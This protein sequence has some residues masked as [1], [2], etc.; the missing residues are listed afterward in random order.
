MLHAAYVHAAYLYI[1]ML[2]HALRRRSQCWRTELRLPG[3]D[4]SHAFARCVML[5]NV[6]HRLA[7]R[8]L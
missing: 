7:S 6:A 1:C 2:C 8:V 4:P 5:C 3:S